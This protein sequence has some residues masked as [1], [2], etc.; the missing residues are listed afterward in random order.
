MY[1]IWDSLQFTW[2]GAQMQPKAE[3][4]HRIHSPKHHGRQNPGFPDGD[5]RLPSTIGCSC[6]RKGRETDST[7]V[8]IRWLTS[9]CSNTLCVD[10]DWVYRRNMQA[11]F[12]KD[13]AGLRHALEEQW[14]SIGPS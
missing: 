11:V 9:L 3:Q 8:E 4:L 10:A 14:I 6:G 5:P 2:E 13:L 1:Y 12:E 7:F